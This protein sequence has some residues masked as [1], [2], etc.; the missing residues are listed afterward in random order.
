[1][2]LSQRNFFND[3]SRQTDDYL[4]VPLIWYLSHIA[5]LL[6]LFSH[7]ILEQKEI[8]FGKL[9]YHQ[10]KQDSKESRCN[11]SGE[12]CGQVENIRLL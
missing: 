12:G 2:L 1:M 11:G 6:K 8:M 10:C 5:F 7:S 4:F 9:Q 3:F